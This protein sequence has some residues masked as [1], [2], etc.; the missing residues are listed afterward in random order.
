MWYYQKSY[1]KTVTNYK[2]KLIPSKFIRERIRFLRYYSQHVSLHQ[3]TLLTEWL[4]REFWLPRLHISWIWPINHFSH[5]VLVT[6]C[7]HRNCQP[8]MEPF[9][10]NLCRVFSAWYRKYDIDAV[11]TMTRKDA[12]IQCNWATHSLGP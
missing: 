5:I 12:S 3:H 1:Y 9:W 2:R 7:T 6:D 4:Q 11:G 10:L 8:N